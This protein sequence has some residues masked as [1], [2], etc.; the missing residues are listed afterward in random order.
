MRRERPGKPG[1][2]LCPSWRAFLRSTQTMVQA[3]Q[4]R[5]AG[6][7]EGKHAA[8]RRSRAK[9]RLRWEPGTRGGAGPHP[10]QE[11]CLLVTWLTAMTPKGGNGGPKEL[12]T[13]AEVGLGACLGRLGGLEASPLWARSRAWA[14]PREGAGRPDV[15]EG[16]RGPRSGWPGVLGP[17]DGPGGPSPPALGG[18][19]AGVP[20]PKECPWRAQILRL[21]PSDS[22]ESRKWA[23]PLA[24][25]Q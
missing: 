6:T 18:E 20:S 15:Q 25:W 9:V 1:A 8:W 23:A 4:R 2:T 7:G 13:G 22:G 3:V 17:G 24:E 12:G 19:A 14:V 21:T 16:C 10:L 5:G 11:I